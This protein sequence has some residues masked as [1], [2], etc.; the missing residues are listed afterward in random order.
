MSVMSKKSFRIDGRAKL[1]THLLFNLRA[2]VSG[3]L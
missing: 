2:D 1:F 3:I